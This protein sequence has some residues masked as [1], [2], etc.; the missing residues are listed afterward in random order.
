MDQTL[1]FNRSVLCI[2]QWQVMWIFSDFE[3][4]ETRG[5]IMPFS[6]CHRYG[7]IESNGEGC[8]K[9]GFIADFLVGNNSNGVT[10]IS[11]LLFADDTL[12]FCDAD[13]GQ[14]QALRAVL[15]CFETVLGLKMNLGKSELE[16]VGDMRNINFLANLLGCIDLP[17]K[18]L[19]L[20]L[21]A[22]FKA[23]SIWDGV[24]EKIEKRLSGWKRI[25]LSKEGRLTLIK[26]TLSNLPT[27]YLSLFPLPV[28]VANRMEKLF[29]AFLWGGMGEENKFHLV[30]WQRV[31]CPFVNG[32]L[33]M[34]NLS[35][36]NKTS[37]GKW[38][39]RYQMKENSLWREVIDQKY[40]SEFFGGWGGGDGTLKRVGGRMVLAY[41]NSLE[42][43]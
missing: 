42:R 6:F 41:V 27:Y 34:R 37:V 19:G 22:S 25:Y 23:K 39:W 8:M 36:F 32:G 40:G 15:L 21:G 16:L 1:C 43:G 38:L 3:G 31:C 33:G 12:I 29:R 20:P 4:F 10:S 9:G 11:H 18:Y 7:G 14:I 26:S 13:C 2:S 24:V 35:I 5:P 17:M 30:N 28:G